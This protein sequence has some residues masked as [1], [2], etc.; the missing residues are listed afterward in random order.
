MTNK[1]PLKD[2]EQ[3]FKRVLTYAPAMLGNDAVNFFK[4]SFKRQAWL[5]SRIEPLKPRKAVTKWGKTPR[6]NGRAVVIC[7]QFFN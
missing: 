5:G 3:Q 7:F 4:D 6:N 2:I 1:L